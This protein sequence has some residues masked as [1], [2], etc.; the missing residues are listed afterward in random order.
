MFT[1]EE[2]QVIV[3]L[4]SRTNITGQES[5]VVAQLLNKINQMLQ[6]QPEEPKGVNI[7]KEP[8]ETKK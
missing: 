7:P 2:L 5:F 6:A 3:Q 1:K 4:I 8:K